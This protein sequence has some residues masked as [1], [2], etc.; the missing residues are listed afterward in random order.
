VNDRQRRFV[1]EYC[2]DQNATQAAIRAGYS[3]KTAYSIGQRLLKKVEIKEA[4]DTEYESIR[5]KNILKA[6][7][8]EEMLSRH[9]KREEEDYQV[10]IVEKPH[11]DDNGNYLGIEKSPEIVRLP[12]QNKDAIKALELLGKRYSLW[13]DKVNVEGSIPVVIKDD[14]E[15]DDDDD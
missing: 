8:I 6:R 1:S 2:I 15:D 10:V 12:T 3:E 13:T 7:D 4:I 9:A 5:D 11:Y 14:L